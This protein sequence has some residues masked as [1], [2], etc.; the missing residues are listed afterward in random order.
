MKAHGNTS[1]LIHRIF[2]GMLHFVQHDI[3]FPMKYIVMLNEVKH[4]CVNSS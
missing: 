2:M 3:D 1:L 4:L